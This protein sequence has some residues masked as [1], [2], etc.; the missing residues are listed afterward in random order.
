MTKP[1]KILGALLSLALGGILALVLL[2]LFCMSMD[3]IGYF[4][5]RPVSSDTAI[6]PSGDS[7]FGGSAAI[8]LVIFSPLAFLFGA[9]TLSIPIY[10][11]LF[12]RA[13]KN[14]TG[15]PFLMLLPLIFGSALGGITAFYVGSEVVQGA[16][17]GGFFGLALG[18]P[19]LWLR[20]RLRVAPQ[21]NQSP[22][23][24]ADMQEPPSSSTHSEE[25][26]FVH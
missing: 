26:P 2:L 8:L 4:I 7:T 22:P 3:A 12:F 16:Q 14:R 17:W 6:A 24:S 21:M 11:F 10:R 25:D 1:E 19:S 5:N 20:N 23:T 18:L 15:K 13:V 9:L